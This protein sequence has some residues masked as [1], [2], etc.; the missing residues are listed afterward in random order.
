MNDSKDSAK[1][2]SK[3]FF[4]DLAP[5]VTTGHTWTL[6]YG[7]FFTI[8]LLTFVS[9]GT[10][11]ILNESLNIPIE[12]QGAVTGDL[13]FWTE[14]AQIMLFV[15]V[16]ILAD[17][18]G[19]RSVYAVGLMIM[20]LAYLLYPLATSLGELTLY[21][22]MYAA[23]VAAAAGMLATVVNDYPAEAS[24]GKMVAIVGHHERSRCG[25]DGHR[26]WVYA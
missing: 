15:A 4:I 14:V 6:L 18:I 7:A 12:E 13:G 1:S 3:F 20:G 23:G 5:G 24:R 22:V 9:I 25:R 19:R 17:K 26:F 2:G 21:R 10:P 8:G 16:G 11:L